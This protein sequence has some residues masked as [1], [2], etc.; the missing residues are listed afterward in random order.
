MTKTTP[1]PA[2]APPVW[3]AWGDLS[4]FFALFLDNIINLVIL[5]S[6]LV[7]T[8]QFPKE[9]V[10]QYMIPGTAVGVMIGDLVYSWMAIRMQKRLGRVI[11]AMPLGLDTPSTVGIALV[12]LGPVFLYFKSQLIPTG[13][14]GDEAEQ[15]R[16]I[17]QAG[18]YTW[19]VGSALLI[20]MGAIKFLFSFFGDWVSRVVP[21]AGLL[22]SLA[23]IGMVWLAAEQFIKTMHHPIVGMLALGIITISL[24]AQLRLPAHLPGAAMAVLAGAL[25]YYGF[26][27]I[28]YHHIEMPDGNTLGLALPNLNWHAFE[29]LLEGP[30]TLNYL[31]IA[32]PFGLL[33]IIGGINICVAA[34]ISGDPFRTRN[35]LL[36]DA[37]A[38]FGAGLFGGV[39]QSTPYIGHGAYKAMGA[40]SGYTLATGLLIGIGGSLGL[41]S[42]LVSLIPE[43]AVAPILIFVGFEISVAA[44][45]ATEKRYMV[46]TTFAIIPSIVNFGYI[47]AKTVIWGL[48]GYLGQQLSAAGVKTAG[49]GTQLGTLLTEKTGMIF[50][51]PQARD[52]GLVAALEAYPALEVIPWLEALGQGFIITAM[53]WGAGVSFL[54]DR[55]LKRAALTFAIGGL[56]TFFGVI[57]SAT[58]SGQVYLPWDDFAPNFA[59]SIPFSFTLGYLLV[60][61]LILFLHLYGMMRG[62]T[63]P[64]FREHSE[65]QSSLSEDAVHD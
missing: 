42:Y 47:K 62:S 25:V 52:A 21:V 27:F 56:L 24:I 13:F 46:A 12:V 9:V 3:F 64:P 35:I 37:A 17:H 44:Y 51:A 39:S 18:M 33:T 63:Q 10:F 16:L 19:Y 28:G 11:T 30:T 36:T 45:K 15:A 49:P 38:T 22:G 50:T 5:S 48:A 31:P 54:I 55:K 8:F 1:P 7:Y 2:K 59:H 26:H 14:T 20:W 23:G 60:A 57:H 34:R 40:R 32:L 65:E 43:S 53:I 4:A 29:R 41:V 6:I 61:G 58:S